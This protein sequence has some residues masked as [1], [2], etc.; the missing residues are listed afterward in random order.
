MSFTKKLISLGL[1]ISLWVVAGSAYAVTPANTQLINSALLTYSGNP[2]GV[3]SSVIVTIELVQATASIATTFT[4]PQSSVN[5]ADNQVY[6][7][8]YVIQS[9]ANG[10]DTYSIASVYESVNDVVG[11]V[12]PTT[13][14][15]S[16]TLGATAA[17]AIAA[18]GQAIITVPA[19]GTS[20]A[21][22]NGLEAG[23][24]VVIAGDIYTILSVVDNATGN[25]TI[26][27]A[28]NLLAALAVGD[29]IYEYRSFTV[30]IT[31][32]GAAGGGATNR[33]DLRTT[34]TTSGPASLVF[35]YDVDINIVAIAI[36][37]YVREISGPCLLTCGG[38]VTTSYDSGSGANTYYDAG[39]EAAPGETL[40]YLLVVTTVTAGITTALVTDGLPSDFS[41]YVPGS[42]RLNGILVNDDLVAPIFPMDSG[43]SGGGLTIDDD[44][45]RVA[46]T[47]GSGTVGTNQDVFIVYQIVVDS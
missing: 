1:T 44:V 18:S 24:T 34:V 12:A 29:A 23:D 3:S 22:V 45:A 7:A 39:V 26:T 6:A 15:A 27:L 4:A 38:A 40:E 25:S 36:K 31:D 41:A 37:K 11:S 43:A 13:S 5:Q 30:D 42:T 47:E 19:D 46:G 35:T 8:T 21:N 2:T 9:N 16:F 28:G 10:P 14:I 33:L 17:V 20:D 32:I